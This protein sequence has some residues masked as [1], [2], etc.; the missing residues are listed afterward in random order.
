MDRL[1]NAGST[2]YVSSVTSQ[3]MLWYMSELAPNKGRPSTYHR[4]CRP[5]ERS[6]AATVPVRARQSI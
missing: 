4:A 1:Y 5:S 6:W 2:V 3:N